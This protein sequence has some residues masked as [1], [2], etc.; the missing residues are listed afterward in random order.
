MLFRPL[1]NFGLGSRCLVAPVQA[2]LAVAGRY[3]EALACHQAAIER[4]SDDPELHSRLLADLAR[5]PRTSDRDLAEAH[6]IWQANHG[7]AVAA[8]ALPADIDADP[9]RPLRVAY[10]SAAF[11]ANDLMQIFEPV[12]RAHRDGKH[13]Q[14]VVPC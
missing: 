14:P 5:K 13:R 12:L 7:A 11:Y 1:A 4:K 8:R 3:E 6:D 10:L 2:A 9:E